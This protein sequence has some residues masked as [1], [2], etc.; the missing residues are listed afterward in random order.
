MNHLWGRHFGQPIVATPENFGLNGGLPTHPELL[1]WLATELIAHDW[2]MKP[3][4]RELVL[5]ATYRMVSELA[6]SDESTSTA[7][8]PKNHYLWR[9]NSRRM[10]AEVVRDSVLSVADRLDRRL[11]GPEIPETDGEH[12]LRRSLYF[13]NTPNEKMLMLEVFDVADPNACYRRKESIVPHQSLAMMNS[14]IAL[15]SAR[16]LATELADEADFVLAAFRAVLARAPTA[17]EADRCQT[18]L[19]QHAKLLQESP[20]QAFPAG[21]STTQPAAKDALLRAKQNLVHVLLLHN[22]FVTIR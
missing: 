9:M 18:F 16:I 22:D 11:G 5:S 4:H 10:E 1:D 8:D 2:R 13:R 15:D 7:E 14:G 20:R 12:V 17:E 6:S 3:L 21:G 19:R